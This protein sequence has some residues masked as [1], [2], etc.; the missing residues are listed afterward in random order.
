[1]RRDESNVLVSHFFIARFFI[2]ILTK[3]AES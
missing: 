2:E 1:M 3:Y